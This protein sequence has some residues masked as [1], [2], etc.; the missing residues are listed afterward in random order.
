M[1]KKYCGVLISEAD[2][3]NQLTLRLDLFFQQ[4]AGQ[5]FDVQIFKSFQDLNKVADRLSLILFFGMGDKFKDEAKEL[6]DKGI[7]VIFLYTV[8]KPEIEG[9]ETLECP[10]RH[11]AFTE[12]LMKVMPKP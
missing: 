9:V 5:D 4:L 10:F 7:P 11:L 3:R 2:L 8:F 1:D 6:A 12:L